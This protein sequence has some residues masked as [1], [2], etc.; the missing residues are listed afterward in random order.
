MKEK[1]ITRRREKNPLGG[2]ALWNWLDER[3]IFPQLT[4]L[5]RKKKLEKM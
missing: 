5:K 2:V 3:K 1:W 4:P